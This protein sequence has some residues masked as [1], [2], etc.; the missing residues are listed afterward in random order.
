MLTASHPVSCGLTYHIKL[1]I[2]DG[3]DSI[4]ES[5][6]MLEEGSFGSPISTEYEATAAQLVIQIQMMTKLFT[7]HGKIVEYLQLQSTDLV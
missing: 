1:A 5:I 4:L 6:V 7:V 2:A 3:S